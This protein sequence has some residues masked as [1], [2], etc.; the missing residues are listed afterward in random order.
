MEFQDDDQS[1]NGDFV[2]SSDEDEV[3]SEAEPRYRYS[4]N[5]YYPIRIGEV[6]AAGYRIEHKLGW[7]G[8]STVPWLSKSWSPGEKGEREYHKQ[9][10][11]MEKVHDISGLV[12]YQSCF[13]L[14]GYGGV[15]KHMVLVFPV[16]G[17]SL[18][19]CSRRG[20]R[21]PVARRVRA[22][23]QLLISVKGLHD[24]GIIH[25]DLNKGAVLYDMKKDPVEN[26]TT[27]EEYRRF[28]GRPRKIA[29]QE[30]SRKQAELVEPMAFPADRISGDKVYLCDFHLCSNN[31][32]SSTR[33]T[34]YKVQSPGMFC[35]PERFHGGVVLMDR[36]VD[37]LGPFPA[38]WK[39]RHYLEH[40]DKS[41]WYDPNP[42]MDRWYDPGLKTRVDPKY[43]LEAKIDHRTRPEISEYERQ[44][45]LNVMYKGFRYLPEERITAAELLQDE[46]FNIIMGLYGQ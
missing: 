35:A 24:A 30:V 26:L 32:D 14:V 20:M 37:A 39:G 42:D 28:L 16:R 9:N 11:I 15:N 3:E 23:K 34:D 2:C 8:F 31:T 33:E 22:A 40:V 27:A 38:H 29:L 45:A 46:S 6:L 21:G 17:P 5:L 4:E 19:Y 12:T 1:D 43:S 25:R 36:V 7:G 10:E 18:Y 44:H 13:C 41:G